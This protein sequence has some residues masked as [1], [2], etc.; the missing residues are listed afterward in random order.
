MQARDMV[1][2]W[3]LD[4]AIQWREAEGFQYAE[5][6]P[7]VGPAAIADV[8]SMRRLPIGLGA[9]FAL[10]M[11]G[12]LA[13]GIEVATRARRRELA[14]FRALGGTSRQVA[15]SVRWHALTVASLAVAVGV[16]LGVAAGRVLY[17]N[18]AVDIGVLPTI[19]TSV[20]ALAGVAVGT[21]IVALLAGALPAHRISSTQLASS[22]R[23]E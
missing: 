5:G 17:R 18:F 21:V 6:N 16:P 2:S 19:D 13:T 20:P 10:A 9:F 7:Y 8:A 4:P 14:V 15:S 23:Q 1:K 12:G 22:L 11:A 3:H